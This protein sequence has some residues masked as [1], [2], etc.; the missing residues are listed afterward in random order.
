MNGVQRR[1]ENRKG[2]K[3]EKGTEEKERNGGK[4]KG[5][6]TEKTVLIGS[7]CDQG[8][9][10]SV[11]SNPGRTRPNAARQSYVSLADFFAIKDLADFLLEALLD[12]FANDFAHSVCHIL[13]YLNIT[14][15]PK[16]EQNVR[17]GFRIRIDL[18]RIRIRI[19]NFL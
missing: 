2:W 15:L 7:K 19:Q 13:S 16:R 1:I 11:N 12:F 8:S 3:T 4:R 18:M 5:W 14:N 6:R 17:T 9:I 10:G